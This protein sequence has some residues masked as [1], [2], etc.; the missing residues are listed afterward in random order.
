MLSLFKISPLTKLN[1][2]YQ[3]KLHEAM[4]AQR[5]GNIRL[6][7]ELSREADSIYQQIRAFEG[8]F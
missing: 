4:Q 6:Y 5:S 3:K 2:Q 7:A 8:D 1:K